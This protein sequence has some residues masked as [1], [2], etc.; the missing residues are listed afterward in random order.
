[1]TR[2]GRAR[3]ILLL[4]N[5]PIDYLLR[6]EFATDDAA[7][8]TS[9][10]VGEVGSV[11]ITDTGDNSEVS[12]GAWRFTNIVGSNDPSLITATFT[13]S[14]GLM[15]SSR[16]TLADRSQAGLINTLSQLVLTVDTLS[17]RLYDATDIPFG[18]DTISGVDSTFYY[19]LQSTGIYLFRLVSGTVKL[20]WYQVDN[21]QD[22]SFRVRAVSGTGSRVLDYIRARQLTQAEWTTQNGIMTVDQSTPSSGTNYTATADALHDIAFTLDGSPTAN[23]TIELRYR[24]QDANNY[25]TAFIERNGSNT[26]WDVQLDS[27]SASIPTN[28]ISVTGVGTPDRLRVICD[29]SKHNMFTRSGISWTKRGGTVSVSHLNTETAIN[30]TYDAGNTV[31]TLLSIPRTSVEY[32]ELDRS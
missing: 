19:V 8:V 32:S 31:S 20:I 29:G 15:F 5:N 2:R 11:T 26:A 17:D 9:P 13:R 16:A 27:V 1:M 3:D 6:V 12:A 30:T 21:T 4:A 25:W 18:I 24:V 14:Q 22:L 7:P 23:E 10:Y 28:R